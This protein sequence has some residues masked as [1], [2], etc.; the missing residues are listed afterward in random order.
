MAH[1]SVQAGTPIYTFGWGS[2]SPFPVAERG[3]GI[4]LFGW[5]GGQPD[6]SEY[7]DEVSFPGCN[8]GREQVL[9]V[10]IQTEAVEQA[11]VQQEGVL[12]AGL[13]RE[14]TRS[15]NI[16]TEILIPGVER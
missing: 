10:S 13:A 11:S 2:L 1:P 5:F 7:P 4:Y 8:L 9:A 12:Q 6:T 16:G 15:A 3:L 14:S